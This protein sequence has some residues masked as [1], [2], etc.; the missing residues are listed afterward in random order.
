[1]NSMN[2]D[3]ESVQWLNKHIEGV[4]KWDEA[5]REGRYTIALFS[6]V[7]TDTLSG[8]LKNLGYD[9]AVSTRN[10]EGVSAFIIIVKK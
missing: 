8:E 1:M 6:Q 3:T 5:T 10:H 7:D 9:V 2:D 4:K